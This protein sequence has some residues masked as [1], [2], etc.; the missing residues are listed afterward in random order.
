VTLVDNHQIDVAD[1]RGPITNGLDAS[2]GDRLLQILAPQAGREHAQR[3]AGPVL[4]HLFGVLLNQLFDVR[5]HE[6]ARLGVGLKRSLAQGGDNVALA[7]ASRKHEARVAPVAGLKPSVEFVYDALLIAAKF[8]FTTFASG[9]SFLISLT[10]LLAQPSGLATISVDAKPV[11]PFTTSLP[12][13][14]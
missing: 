1:L 12:L 11:L 9:H 4:K 8:H 3:S 6:D 14:I 7:C 2:E 5:Q 13:M 10:T